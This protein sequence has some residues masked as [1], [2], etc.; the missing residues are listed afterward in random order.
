MSPLVLL[1]CVSLRLRCRNLSTVLASLFVRLFRIPAG[2]IPTG[3][4]SN[5]GSNKYVSI[6]EVRIDRIDTPTGSPHPDRVPSPRRGPPTPT[7]S[8][9]PDEV[10][11]PRRG[12]DR[13]IMDRCSAARCFLSYLFTLF[14][15]SG[16]GEGTRQLMPDSTI[17]AAG[18][19]FIN[20]NGASYPNFGIAGCDP[21]YRINIHIKNP[22]EVILIGMNCDRANLHFNLRN[23]AGTIVKTGLCPYQPS[24]QGYIRY[25][26]QAVTGPFPAIGGYNP[27]THPITSVAD[28]GLYYFELAD[29]PYNYTTIFDYW[30][31]QVVSGA[32]APAIP[33]DTI[34]GRV[35]SKSWQFYADLGNVVFQPFNGRVFVYSDDGIVTRLAFSDAHVGAM[36]LFCNPYGCLNTGNFLSDRQSQNFNTYAVF[37][38][39]AQ[40]RVFLNDPDSTLYPGGHYGEITGQPFMLPDSSYPPCSGHQLIVVNVDKPGRIEITINFPYGGTSAMVA[41]Y[42]PVTPG[43]NAVPWNGL[44]GM[45][46]PVPD[47]TVISV[48]VKYLNGLTNLPIWDQERNPQGYQISLIRPVHPS[49]P[50]PMTYWDDS[51]LTVGFMCSNPPQ[52]FNLDGCSPGS[53][54]GYPGCHPWGPAGPDCHDKMINTWWFGSTSTATF[55]TVFLSAPAPP[56]GHDNSRCGPGTVIISASVPPQQTVDWFAT[57]T[58]GTALLTGDTVFTTPVITTTTTYYAESRNLA[59]GCPGTART[60][61]TATIMPVPAPLLTGPGSACAGTTG[62]VYSTEPGKTNYTWKV[63]PGGTIVS[64]QWTR[65]ITL[66]WNTPGDQAVSVNYTDP[67]RCAAPEPTVM[68]VDVIPLPVPLFT[69]PDTACVAAHGNVYVTEPGML[70]Y[71]WSV[72]P[73]GVITGGAGTNAINVT[74]IDGGMQEVSLNCISMEGCPSASPAVLEVEVTPLPGPAGPILGPSPVCEGSEGLVYRV[75]EVP[76][77]TGY[78]WTVTT[79]LSIWSGAGTS[80]VTIAV[81]SGTPSGSIVVKGVNGCGGGIPS[82]PFNLEI[83]SKALVIAGDSLLT[84]GMTPV[85]PSGSQG[86]GYLSLTWTTS[87]SG[88]FDDPHLLYPTY[89]PDSSDVQAGKV[90]LTLTATSALPCP[91]ESSAVVLNIVKPPVADAGTDRRTCEGRQVALQGTAFNY[92]YVEW[93]TSGDGHFSDP[94][95]MN[96]E[97]IPGPGDIVNG[98]AILMLEASSAAPCAADVDS[99]T[100][101]IDPAPLA[102]AGENGVVCKGIPYVLSGSMARNYSLVEW[103]HSGEGMLE[104][105]HTLNPVY[106]PAGEETGVISLRLRATGTQSCFDAVAGDTVLL[107]IYDPPV[108]DA[109]PDQLIVSGSSA[110]LQ[111]NAAGGSGQFTWHWEPVALVVDPETRETMTLSL[112]TDTTFLLTATDRVS[113]C[114]AGDQVRLVIG[115]EPVPGDNCIV[116]HDVITPNGDGL[117]DTWIIDCIDQFPLNQVLIFDR[118]GDRVRQFDNYNNSSVSWDGTNSRGEDL[119]DGTYYYILTISNGARYNGWIL[120]RGN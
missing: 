75:G 69:G 98:K 6:G 71:F 21:N 56:A 50:S 66:T 80:S 89:T 5:T 62:H 22:G 90:V 84:C 53:I 51:P 39:I 15:A 77:A 117:N 10:P 81:A 116:I 49:N 106:Y 115:Q 31:L 111:G 83:S 59:T 3:S 44:D 65:M 48:A 93:Q 72:S 33:T 67:N 24:Q 18:L 103:T 2:I 13:R 1:G 88:I 64:G 112:F 8:P 68:Q 36:T 29:L 28:T 40:Y 109:G 32:H 73:G 108:A 37:P 87:G 47:G 86:Q 58:G 60:P 61:V 118:W 113:G 30:D 46:N 7:G 74:W 41:L 95:I 82:D 63:S 9:H 55:D 70:E 45:G 52:N 34:N 101:T 23:A 100:L 16:F 25:Y 96:P 20:S 19:Y 91:A 12:I 17:S 79:G 11:P 102:F 104:G 92:A 35:W 4:G 57:F 42:S 26:R 97:Y 114:V 105:A 85:T 14:V 78:A 43:S 119:P 94:G 54:P 110:L 38:A 107:T 99:I 76:W 27:I 120:V